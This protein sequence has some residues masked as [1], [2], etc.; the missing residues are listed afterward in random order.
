MVRHEGEAHRL[1]NVLRNNHKYQ[2]S[3]TKY[4]ADVSS[5]LLS[6]FSSCSFTSRAH[7]EWILSWLHRYHHQ[8][9]QLPYT[10][11]KER[12]SSRERQT[13]NSILKYL[14]NSDYIVMQNI[15]ISSQDIFVY[16]AE[17]YF[18]CSSFA[19]DA[20]TLWKEKE[21]LLYMMAFKKSEKQVKSIS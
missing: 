17:C 14:R 10:R 15:F 11:G 21:C 5:A 16:T 6:S 19:T 12:E 1:Q 7:S 8:L 3:S 9:C 20:Q 18:I 2:P 13:H 4:E